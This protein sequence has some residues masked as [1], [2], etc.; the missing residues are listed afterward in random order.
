MKK[1]TKSLGSFDSMKDKEYD[2]LQFRIQFIQELIGN[3]P[4][5]PMINIDDPSTENFQNPFRGKENSD[6]ANNARYV[7]NKKLMN[8]NSIISNIG[9]K[10]QYIKSG[11]TGHAFK[12]YVKLED[13]KLVN[14]GIKMVAYSR[15]YGSINDIKRPENAELMMIKLLSYFVLKK[16]TPYIILP[17]TTFNTNIDTFVKLAYNNTIAEKD[18]NGDTDVSNDKFIKFVRAYEN[19]DYHDNVSVLV[20]EWANRGDLLSFIKK[21][22]KEFSLK[23]WK[24][25]FFQII[26]VLAIIQNKYPGFRHN[27]LK[28]NNILIHH[29]L[30]KT[31]S[32]EHTIN[33]YKYIVPTIGYQIKLWDFDFACIPGIVN[34]QKVSDKWTTE[35]NINPVQN[36]YYDIHYFFNTLIK[37]NF[38]GKFMTEECVPKEA[39]DFVNRIVPP[40]YQVG[41]N[42]T[43]SRKDRFALSIE[44][45]IPEEILRTDIFFEEFRKGVVEKVKP[46][47]STLNID[48]I[49]TDINKES[50]PQFDPD[51][52]Y[53]MNISSK[54]GTNVKTHSNRNF[55]RQDRYNVNVAKHN[56]KKQVDKNID[57][58]SRPSTR[59]EYIPQHDN[60][61][62]NNRAGERRYFLDKRNEVDINVKKN[63]ASKSKVLYVNL[64]H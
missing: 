47:D 60:T 59:R 29:V 20:C 23:H 63:N 25:I 8:F 18:E 13:G 26:S 54:L 31:E 14:F 53:N 49:F 36:R 16:Q 3:T 48:S 58:N 1:E 40:K 24:V 46:K 61:T 45:M 7:L 12:G 28:A 50:A 57:N 44:Y 35:L 34:N 15:K 56:A 27:D 37:K 21:Y 9:G 11:S 42:L 19:G 51:S 2:T 41:E 17:I 43:G 38:F 62:R 5:E 32:V 55:D 22:Y 6:K 33:Y 10:L 39:K 64:D 52:Q 4:L 30:N